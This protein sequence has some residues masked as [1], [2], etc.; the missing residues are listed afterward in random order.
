MQTTHP[1]EQRIIPASHRKMKA[2]G[3]SHSPLG[4]RIAEWA[5]NHPRLIV[6]TGLVM[7]GLL[8]WLLKRKN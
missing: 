7:G 1:P 3:S 2:Q 5:G 4:D 8:G 6:S